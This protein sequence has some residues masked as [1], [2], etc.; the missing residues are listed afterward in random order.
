MDLS[1]QQTLDANPNAMQQMTF[2][3]NLTREEGGRIY[4]IIE[5]AKE[6]VLGFSKGTVKVL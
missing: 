4:F 6:T 1:Q 5:E 3:G 2:T